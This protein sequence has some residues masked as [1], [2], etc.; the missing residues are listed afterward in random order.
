MTLYSITIVPTPVEV[1]TLPFI[2]P[3]PEIRLNTPPA[4]VPVSGRVSP[5]Q[6]GPPLLVM[7]GAGV[8]FETMLWEVFPVHPFCVTVY[9]T[10]IVPAPLAV[11]ISPLMVPGPERTLYD[12]PVGVPVKVLVSPL[13]IGELLLVMVGAGVRFETMD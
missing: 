13:H 2:L 11:R 1:S 3:G 12:P 5:V 10:T 9:C 7:T 4:G 8:W 6:I